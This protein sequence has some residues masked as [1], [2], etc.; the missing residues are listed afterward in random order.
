MR[1]LG[2]IIIIFFILLIIPIVNDLFYW[3]HVRNKISSNYKQWSYNTGDLLLFT[4]INDSIFAT[5]NNNFINLEKFN[6]SYHHNIVPNLFNRIYTHI[7]MVIVVNDIP[8]IY[9]LTL[10]DGYIYKKNYDHKIPKFC[11][12]KN[13]YFTDNTPSLININYLEHY[14]GHVYKLPYIGPTIDPKLISYTLNKNKR[15]E[16]LTESTVINRCLLNNKNFKPDKMICSTFILHVLE[17]LNVIKKNINKDCY[18][19]KDVEKLCIESG[20]Y[21]C[22]KIDFTLNN[23]K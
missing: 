21:D 22:S 11:I 20:K 7:G 15:I 6:K 14:G 5:K 18:L 3:S 8:H 2:Y 1:Y 19:P 23:Y 13:E 12:F 4:W 16:S 17:D 9:E 10:N